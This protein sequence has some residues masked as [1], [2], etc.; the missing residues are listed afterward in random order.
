MNKLLTSNLLKSQQFPGM[1]KIESHFCFYQFRN[2]KNS[3]IT[4]FM[5]AM[6][7]MSLWKKHIL[8]LLNKEVN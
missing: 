2:Q 5:T 3:N 1:E 6:I 7:E 4:I 8:I